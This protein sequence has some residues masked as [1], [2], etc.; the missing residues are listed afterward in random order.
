MA[1]L[2]ELLCGFLWFGSTAL[3]SFHAGVLSLITALFRWNRPPTTTAAA[4]AKKS[5]A[6]TETGSATLS[7]STYQ[8]L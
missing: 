3:Q 2:V 7:P 6:I 8:W 1:S 5:G 4:P